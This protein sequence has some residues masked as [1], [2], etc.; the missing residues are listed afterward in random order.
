MQQPL[1]ILLSTLLVTTSAAY[2][3]SPWSV[4]GGVIAVD[5]PYAN[6]DTKVMALPMINYQGEK[7]TLRGYTLD[8]TLLQQH[9]FSWSATLAPGQFFDSSDSD[10]PAIKAL[11]ERKM[12]LYA[13]TKVSYA[14]SFGRVSAS[15]SHDILGNGDGAKFKTDYSYPVKLTKEL[16]LAP[17]VGVEINSSQLSNYYYGVAEGESSTFDAYE[18]SST[19]NYN[20]GLLA[21]YQLNRNWNV[22]ALV[23]FNQLDADIEDSPIIDTDNLTTAMM[24]ITYHF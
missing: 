10:N 4:A 11:N 23:K 13:G 18:L 9:G 7:L 19:V 5:S 21:S 15:V 3:D 16:M 22:N 2:A 14:A 17:F 12:S 1:P 24:S 8:Y 6:T 20:I